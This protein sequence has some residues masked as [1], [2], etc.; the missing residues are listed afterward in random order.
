MKK[1][2]KKRWKKTSAKSIRYQFTQGL[3]G[4]GRVVACWSDEMGL[5]IRSGPGLKEP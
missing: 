5:G 2:M 1:G 3:G 4:E